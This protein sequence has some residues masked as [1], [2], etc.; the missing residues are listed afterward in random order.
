MPGFDYRWLLRAI[1]DNVYDVDTLPLVQACRAM[2]HACEEEWHAQ[3][4]MCSGK[5]TIS[6]HGISG[7]RDFIHLDHLGAYF[8]R[9]LPLCAQ[10]HEHASIVMCNEE[11]LASSLQSMQCTHFPYLPGG[12]SKDPYCRLE[13]RTAEG[14]DLFVET[15]SRVGARL[16]GEII[17]RG[18]KSLDMWHQILDVLEDCVVVFNG[19]AD[20]GRKH[21]GPALHHLF[22][23][24]PDEV[25]DMFEH[26]HAGKSCESE[27]ADFYH[28]EHGEC[29]VVISVEMVQ[30]G[31]IFVATLHVLTTDEEIPLVGRYSPDHTRAEE[32]GL[33]PMCEIA[34]L[35]PAAKSDWV[36]LDQDTHYYTTD[37]A[38]VQHDV[39]WLPHAWEQYAP[40]KHMLQSG[41]PVPMLVS[42]VQ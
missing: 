25:C 40:V 28:E 39:C 24:D 14:F 8:R 21:A 32:L 10:M 1:L 9:L 6:R 5:F 16:Q 31:L 30:D 38:D 4:L 7:L 26:P 11:G 37:D 27:P 2:R 13:D 20:N 29:A 42:C 15:L 17:I 36:L 23:F 22:E 34:V 19:R 35:G 12:P 41:T 33:S 18:Q 3:L